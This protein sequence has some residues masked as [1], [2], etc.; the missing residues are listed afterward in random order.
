NGTGMSTLYDAAGV[1]QSLRVTVPGAPTGMVW[2]SETGWP[3]DAPC[4]GR[5]IFIWASEDGTISGWN[6]S[7]S[8]QACVEVDDSDEGNVFKGLAFVPD[9]NWIYA[10]DFHNNR[11]E[12]YGPDWDDAPITGSFENKK[13]PKGYAPFGIQFLNGSLFVTYAKQ[14]KLAED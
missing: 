11:I 12:V 2:N 1:K 13:I 7:N 6:P 3:L 5:A 9:K 10:T 8:S 4:S 14:D